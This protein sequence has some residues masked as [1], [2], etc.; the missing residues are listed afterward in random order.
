[1]W[2]A[3]PA[4]SSET[5]LPYNPCVVAPTPGPAERRIVSVLFADLAGSTGVA[6]SLDP[7]D[8]ADLA[9]DALSAMSRA[10][11]RYGGT[12]ARLMGDGI[13]ALFGAPTAREDDA[14]RALRAG[15]EISEIGP[16]LR[17]RAIDMG[18]TLTD[19]ALLVRVGIDTGEVVATTVGTATASEYT[20]LGDTAN[21]AARLEKGSPPGV[22]SASASTIDAAGPQVFAAEVGQVRVDGRVDAVSVWH[23]EGFGEGSAPSV[24]GIVGREAELDRL[25]TLLERLQ[26]D[27]GGALGIVGE[28]GLG[29]SALLTQLVA[30]ASTVPGIAVGRVAAASYESGVAYGLILSLLRWLADHET[31]PSRL[32]SV[33]EVLDG[34]PGEVDP[35][36]VATA[37]SEHIRDRASGPLLLVFDDLH[38]ADHASVEVIGKLLALTERYPVALVWASR[39]YRRSPAWSLKQ[40]AETDYPHIFAELALGPLSKEDAARLAERHFGTADAAVAAAV[41]RAEGNP[42][43]LEELVREIRRGNHSGGVPPSLRVLI[44]AR[45]DRLTDAA[46]TVLDTAAVAGREFD[47]GLIERVLDRTIDDELHELAREGLI[48]PEG[49]DRFRFRHSLTQEAAYDSILGRRRRQTHSAIGSVLEQDGSASHAHLAAHFTRA[50]E[51]ARAAGHWLAAGEEA[52]RLG[53]FS[54]ACM[55]FDRGLGLIDEHDPKW[56]RMLVGRGR[57]REVTGDLDGARADLERALEAAESAGDDEVAW[58][59]ATALGE[60]WAAHDYE[61]TGASY[62]HALE[63]ARRRSDDHAIATTLNRLGNW[64][65]NAVDPGEGILLHAEA[66][67]IFQQLGDPHGVASTH[68]LL[69]MA[70]LLGGD[71]SEAREHF[72]TALPEFQRLGDRRGHVGALIGSALGAP[73]H[74]TQAE[75]PTVSVDDA[76]HAL[77]AAVELAMTLGWPSGEVFARFM[78]CQLRGMSGRLGSAIEDGEHALSVSR[79]IGHEQ[80]VIASLQSLGWVLCDALA[81]EEAEELLIEARALC[82]GVGSKNWNLHVAAVSAAAAIRSGQAERA[83]ELTERSFNDSQSH[84]FAAHRL[85]QLVRAWALAEIGDTP[86]AL[87]LLRPWESAPA[88]PLALLVQGR[89]LRTVDPELGR[90]AFESGAEVARRWGMQSVR[91]QLLEN[92]ARLGSPDAGRVAVGA[93]VECLESLEGERRETMRRRGS[94]VLADWEGD[95]DGVV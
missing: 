35:T 70:N 16:R 31:V 84:R 62:R 53:A 95:A 74:E 79:R 82:E 91:W 89:A 50:D 77:T 66:L 60:V 54:D 67:T 73:V 15:A 44:Q 47:R 17:R 57:A 26:R 85:C 18:A 4:A 9:G 25:Q 90:H 8:W 94:V 75:P 86:G 30:R 19:S 5:N 12:I 88:T 11:E 46:R 58:M 3:E 40:L 92:A 28:A 93:F 71:P 56:G 32:H 48:E 72:L 51:A 83:L 36:I 22:V 68:D 20:V 39:P 76:E 52:A 34:S 80:W 59:A 21:V 13:L 14:L 43:F 64:Y 78:R 37:F 69:G 41:E 61:R 63:I 29:K 23:L 10:V 87:E 38:W 27:R 55:H 45:T 24:A 7:E 42:F 81:F 49:A 33:L 6:E 1:M 65:A 2:A